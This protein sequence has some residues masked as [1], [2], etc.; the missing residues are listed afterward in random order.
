MSILRNLAL[1]LL[2]IALLPWGAYSGRVQASLARVETPDTAVAA[3][4]GSVAM[5]GPSE[6]VQAA[7]VKCRKGLAGSF[8]CAPDPGLL[9]AASP[10]PQA[11]PGSSLARITL[12]LLPEGV[13]PGPTPPPPRAV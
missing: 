13:T 11:R 4:S 9:M 7:W 8:R 5:P 2:L 10:Q 12:A 1:T 6:T 3:G